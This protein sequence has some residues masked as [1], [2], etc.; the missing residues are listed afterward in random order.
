M[1]ITAEGDL[2]GTSLRLQAADSDLFAD[3]EES[4][5]TEAKETKIDSLLENWAR[6][7]VEAAQLKQVRARGI[8]C[9]QRLPTKEVFTTETEN[10]GASKAARK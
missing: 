5:A 4:E 9:S 2:F 8:Y 10:M 6:Q 3:M 7:V 1:A